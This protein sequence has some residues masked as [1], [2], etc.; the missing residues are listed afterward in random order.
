MSITPDQHF[1]YIEGLRNRKGKGDASGSACTTTSE[2]AAAAGVDEG[3]EARIN[4]IADGGVSPEA[5]RALLAEVID[6]ELGV[7]IVSLGLVRKV[8]FA[9]GAFDVEFTVTTPAC[10]LSG[11]IED[12]IRDKLMRL[13]DVDRVDTRLVFEPPWEPEQMSDEARTALGWGA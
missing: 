10:P 4:A 12:E 11:F 9:D 5:A 13:P 7:D 8:S 6:P 3:A 1:A 2:E